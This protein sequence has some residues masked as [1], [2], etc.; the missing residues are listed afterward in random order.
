MGQQGK[1]KCT[2]TTRGRGAGR[3]HL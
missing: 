1:A 2:G 3:R